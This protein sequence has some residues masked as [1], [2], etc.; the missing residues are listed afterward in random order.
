MNIEV[1]QDEGGKRQFDGLD[2]VNRDPSKVYRWAQ[3]RDMAI[4]RHEF[5]GYEKCDSK[6]DKVRSVLGDNTR[7]KKAGDTD[8]TITL[9]DMVLMQIDKEKHTQRM[10]EE[11][12]RIRRSE[13]G[14]TKEFLSKTNNAAGARVAYE[15]HTESKGMRGPTQEEWE[16]TEK[17]GQ[18]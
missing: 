4:A 10:K 1:V 9:G 8:T 16:H 11:G 5:R 13:G 12:E 6:R 2:L 15:D 17:G 14:V 3:K 7:M 18:P